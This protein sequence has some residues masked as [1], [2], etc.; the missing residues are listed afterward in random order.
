MTLKRDVG[1]GETV[2][3]DDVEYD[4][5]LEAVGA[6]REMEVRFGTERRNAAA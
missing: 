2:G 1:A 4:P 3:W 5:T 6:R